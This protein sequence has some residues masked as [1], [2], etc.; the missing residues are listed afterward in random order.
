M[1][2]TFCL[3][4]FCIASALWGA[5]A[6]QINSGGNYW[7]I[8]GG[9]GAANYFGDLAPDD[10]P[11]STNISYTRPSVM[12]G[13]ARRFN[14]RMQVEAEFDYLR[15]MASD[16]R[17]ADPNDQQHKYRYLRNANFRNDVFELSVRLAVDLLP[18]RGYFYR[19]PMWRPYAF[20]GVGAFYHNPKGMT[21]DGKWVALQPLRTEGQGLTPRYNP[22]L[23]YP[24]KPYSLIQFSVPFG[25][26][27]R[28]KLTDNLDLSF[29]FVYHYTFTDYLDD[30]SGNYADPRDLLEQVG[31]L[32]VIMANRTTE[33]VDP[34]TGKTRNFQPVADS[35]GGLTTDEL[36][37]STVVGFGRGGDQRGNSKELDKIITVG[38]KLTYIFAGKVRCPKFR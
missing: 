23:K 28:Y 8:Y 4:F 19:R 2:R 17:N 29:E 31:P 7:A 13:V 35:I 22:D 37:N 14:S 34:I 15:I 1:M 16:F 25:A 12:A 9:L 26:G 30:V 5:Q 33:T 10:N 36:G 11:A 38:F 21:P 6:Q 27:V 32:A 24:D 20:V 3:M 18:S